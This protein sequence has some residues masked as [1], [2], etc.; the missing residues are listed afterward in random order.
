MMARPGKNEKQNVS[1][2]VMSQRTV[3]KDGRDDFPTPPWA[4][5]ALVEYVIHDTWRNYTCLEPACGAGH[6]ARALVPYFKEVRARDVYDYGFA[7]VRDF[8]TSSPRL[9]DGEFDWVITNPPFKLAEEFVVEGLRVARVG[10]AVLVRT[11]FLESGGRYERLFRDRPPTTFAQFVE[12]VPM[13]QGRL[14][15][16]AGTAT[17]YGWMV[18]YRWIDK[19]TAPELMWIPPCRKELERDEDYR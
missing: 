17:S 11:V 1:H 13:V 12:R 18:W 5:R 2:A 4:T 15:R 6:M 8:L 19:R 10:V 9:E 16:E 14:D 7:L 3:S